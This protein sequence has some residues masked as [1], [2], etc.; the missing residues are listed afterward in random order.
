MADERVMTVGQAAE[1]LGISRHHTMVLFKQGILQ[2]YRLSPRTTRI[3]VRSVD[4][5]FDKGS[6]GYLHG[7]PNGQTVH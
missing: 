6:Q 3:F 1:R 4:E 7:N 5:V 2:G